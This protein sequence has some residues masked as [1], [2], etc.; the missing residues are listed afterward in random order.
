MAPFLGL[1]LYLSTTLYQI[2]ISCFHDKCTILTNSGLKAR[3]IGGTIIQLGYYAYYYTG[4]GVNKNA[5]V[6]CGK[7]V[8]VES[9]TRSNACTRMHNIYQ[10]C[11]LD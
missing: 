9:D 3:T 5:S 8:R 11:R 7:L 10:L 2:Q 1:F 4:T 6:T